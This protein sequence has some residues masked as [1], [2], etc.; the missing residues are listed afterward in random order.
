M[1]KNAIIYIDDTT[2]QVTKAFEKQA[3]IFG[4]EEY[5]LWKAYREDFPAAKMVT[6]TIK[7]NPN[8]KSYKNLTYANM[9]L[10]ITEQNSELLVELRKQIKLSKVQSNPYRAVLAWFLSEFPKYDEY[11]EF[12]A[13]IEAEAKNDTTA[14]DEAVA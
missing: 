7:K 1:K 9:E 8:K 14:A 11:K 2:A 6:K 5:K 12:W 4:T 10:F 3:R 13:S